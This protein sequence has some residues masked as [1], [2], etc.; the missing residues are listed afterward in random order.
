M[1]LISIKGEITEIP[2]WD[3]RGKVI[4]DI[5]F[6]WEG[7]TEEKGQYAS[8][9]ETCAKSPPFIGVF[10]LNPLLNYFLCV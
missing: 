7:G 2:N 9:A 1:H 8:L 10:L 4:R 5:F 3:Q 6:I